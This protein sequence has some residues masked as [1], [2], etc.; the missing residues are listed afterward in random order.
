MAK[1]AHRA[2][3]RPL[4]LDLGRRARL[5]LLERGDRLLH[6]S[7]PLHS[8]CS[9]STTGRGMHTQAARTDDDPVPVRLE[10]GLPSRVVLGAILE[11][12]RPRTAAADR[13]A[14]LLVA[15][16]VHRLVSSL[17]SGAWYSTTTTPSGT[18]G[19]SPLTARARS[20]AAA[21]VTRSP[22]RYGRQRR[23]EIRTRA[24]PHTRERHHFRQQ[25]EAVLE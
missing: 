10:V 4:H 7:P 16:H 24:R 9:R 1:L 21:T 25:P 19:S 14:R 17:P 6:G 12:K 11:R 13:A 22:S 18:T 2:S 20:L 3:A 23:A 8:P 5:V 15:E